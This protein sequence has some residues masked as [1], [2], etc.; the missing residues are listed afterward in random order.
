[1]AKRLGKSIATVRRMEGVELHPMRD[2]RGVNRFDPDEVERL[3]QAE[4]SGSR[5]THSRSYRIANLERLHRRSEGV[6][7]QLAPDVSGQELKRQQENTGGQQAVERARQAEAGR[8][9]E[10]RR[11]RELEAENAALRAVFLKEIVEWIESLSPRQVTALD[12]EGFDE[13]I[14]LLDV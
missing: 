13:L 10:E 2:T 11:R 8:E 7:E 6:E 4:R 1:V 5:A 12:D 14:E 9:A 3:A